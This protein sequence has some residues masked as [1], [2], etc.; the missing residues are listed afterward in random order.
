MLG[1][2]VPNQEKKMNVQRCD[3]EE[4]TILRVCNNQNV[5]SK[6]EASVPFVHTI[7]LDNSG[8]MESLTRVALDTIAVSLANMPNVKHTNVVVFADNADVHGPFKDGTGVSAIQ[9]PYQ[10]GTNLTGAMETAFALIESDKSVCHHILTFLSDGR[11]AS[12]VPLM[13]TFPRF[14]ENKMLTVIIVAIGAADISFGMRVKQSMETV[15]ITQMSNIYYA[16]NQSEFTPTCYDLT[17]ALSSHTAGNT[18]TAWLRVAPFVFSHTHAETCLV[19]LKINEPQFLLVEKPNRESQSAVVLVECKKGAEDGIEFQLLF[20]EHFVPS[21]T[22]VSALLDVLIAQFAR[23]RVS[24]QNQHRA[25]QMEQFKRH[26]QKLQAFINAVERICKQAMECK[27]EEVE[28]DEQKTSAKRGNYKLRLNALHKKVRATTSMFAQQRNVLLDLTAT[29]SNDSAS[30]AAFLTG[31]NN[32]YAGKAIR[33]AGT[34][35]ADVNTIFTR[36]QQQLPAWQKVL[37]TDEDEDANAGSSCLSLNSVRQQFQ[38]WPKIMQECKASDFENVYALLVAFG[39]NGY[40]VSFAHNNAVQMDPFQTRCTHIETVMIDSAMLMLAKQTAKDLL[41]PHSN[42]PLDNILILVD[43]SCPEAGIVAS[44]S[45]VYQYLLSATLA[46]DLY[47]FNPSMTAAMHCHAFV[48]AMGLHKKH[49]EQGGKAYLELAL[50]IA[51]SARKLKF[52]YKDLMTRWMEWHGLTQSQTDNCAHPNMIPLLLAAT[53]CEDESQCFE[54]EF[55]VPCLTLMNE[56]LARKMKVWLI[57]HAGPNGCPKEKAV[58]ILQRIF[59]I[60]AANSPQPHADTLAPEPP[61]EDTKQTCQPWATCNIQVFQQIFGHDK[62]PTDFVSDLIHDEFAAFD[63]GVLLYSS[64]SWGADRKLESDC[65]RMRCIPPNFIES[66]H[67]KLLR[68][69]Y[70][71][72]LTTSLMVSENNHDLHLTMLCQAMLCH[73]SQSRSTIIDHDVRDS[74]TLQAIIIDLRMAFYYEACKVKRSAYMAIIGDV[75]LADALQQDAAAFDRMLTKHTHGLNKEKF[76]A[77]H[78]AAQRAAKEGDCA[79]AEAFVRKS[80][81]TVQIDGYKKGGS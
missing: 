42:L 48:T 45:E 69:S 32:K 10:G 31:I 50:K 53:S 71:E 7:V 74:E 39:L 23:V 19:F 78:E 14:V 11:H 79:K 17:Q 49:K 36:V 30:Q 51:Y 44:K 3:L 72:P 54:A 12:T 33:R 40:P 5:E 27:S 62:T 67:Q 15:P 70:T 38:E 80:N 76:W 2:Q 1:E 68:F 9:L 43:P 63:L 58:E 13:S 46:K 73:D 57:N 4:F 52:G 81:N 47:M 59:G 20:P 24:L 25:V 64:N 61:V 41:S 26:V 77:Y 18:T 8:S 37:S 55:I 6:N 29:L 60:T 75:A 56:V 28:Q 22:D 16:K 35:D 34:I 66:L 65:E 21:E